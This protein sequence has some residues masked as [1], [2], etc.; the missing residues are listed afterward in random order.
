MKI[1]WLGHS[2]FLITSTSGTRVVTDPYAPEVG[3]SFPGVSAE[4][5]TVSHDHFD[6]NNSRVVH[7]APVV[8]SSVGD[9]ERCG[10]RL[11]GIPSYHDECEGAKRGKNTVFLIEVDGVKICH[12][13]DLGEPLNSDLATKLSGVDILLIP[14]GG[15]YTLDA[16]HARE[17]V[18]AIKPKIVIPMHFKS[19]GHA[20]D[21]DGI[22][23]FERA[24]GEY[25]FTHLGAD[26]LPITR[27][28]LD[29][30]DETKIIVLERKRGFSK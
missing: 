12:L 27:A 2:S 13:G 19:S 16:K 23:P 30:I 9:C 1:R 5:V 28:T 18:E 20:F 4:L 25:S 3:F 8:V 29:G 17:Y 11:Q 7:G 21:I 26:T 24:M 6:H 22:E 15:T 14:V 10:V